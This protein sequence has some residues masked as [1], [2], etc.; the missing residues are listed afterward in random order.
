MTQPA[1]RA[2]VELGDTTVTFLPDG[3]GRVD[4]EAAFPLSA[5][6]GWATHGEFLDA[7]GWLPVSV[8]SF[9]VRTP[10][11]AVLVDLGLG[12]VDFEVPGMASFKAGA[13]LDSLA[14]EGLRPADIDTVVFTHLHHDHVGWTSEVAPTPETLGRRPAQGLTFASARHLVSEAEWK[15][16]SGTSS[17]IGPDPLAVQGP[18]EGR[19]ELVSD[20]QEVAAG[21]KIMATPGHTPGHQS[22]VITDRRDGR[23]LIILG[24]VMHCQVQVAESEWGFVFDVDAEQAGETRERLLRELESGETILAAGHFT[25][26]VFGRVLPP[27]A[28]RAWAGGR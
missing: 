28:R 11:Q 5:N 21:V 3:Y 20:G 1:T 17:P 8:G 14:A 25:G 13:L 22:L 7:D 12:V 4:P 6:G 9:L 2:Q 24:D 23:R 19:L 10:D 16:W 18:L 26:H 15:H 27:V